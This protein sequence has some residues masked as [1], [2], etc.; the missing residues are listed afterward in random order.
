MNFKIAKAYGKVLEK[1]GVDQEN[2]ELKDRIKG[3]QWITGNL[4]CDNVLIIINR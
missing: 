4:I 1:D 2:N 3:N